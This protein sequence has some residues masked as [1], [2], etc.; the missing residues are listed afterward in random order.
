MKRNII[1]L[2]A[3]VFLVECSLYGTNNQETKN[4]RDTNVFVELDDSIGT[5][6]ESR[7]VVE[8][9][10][11]NNL[12]N[13]IG[14]NYRINDNYKSVANILNL[15]VNSDDIDS[16]KNIKGVK[17]V[18]KV[19]TFSCTNET[20]DYSYDPFE[21]SDKPDQNYS[22]LD[23]NIPNGL[24][25]GS[26]TMIAVLDDSFNINHEMFK[27]LTADFKYSKDDVDAIKNTDG[28][29]AKDAGYKNNKIPFYYSYSTKDNN[30]T[31][32]SNKTFHGGHVSGIAAANNT[33]EGIS[34]NSQLALMR[35]T[36]ARGS[37]DENAIIAALDDC[38]KLNVDVI[39]MSFGNSFLDYTLNETINSCF[40]NL[41]SLGIQV[42]VATGNDGRTKYDN[43][44][45]EYTSTNNVE[46]GEVG[47]FSGNKNVT[48]VGALNIKEDVTIKTS[49]SSYSG[50]SF[51]ARDQVT[52]HGVN[53]DGTSV[54]EKYEDIKPFYEFIEDG[55]DFAVLDYVVVP[56]LG[57]D[58]D[59]NDID[60]NGKIALISRGTITFV[61][62][63]RNAVKHG[64]KGVII[65][66]N[67]DNENSLDSTYIDF[68]GN[69]D[70]LEDEYY[71]PIA[72]TNSWAGELLLNQD[73]KKIIVGKDMSGDYSSEGALS[74]LSLK[75]DISAPGTNIYSGTSTDTDGVNSYAYYDGTSMA[76]PNFSGAY[77]NILSNYSGDDVVAYKKSLVARM[78]STA[79]PLKD[80]NGS[81]YSPR[82]LGAGSVDANGALLSEVYLVGNS[83]NKAKIELKNNN[84]VKNGRIKFS[85]E[86]HNESTESKKYKATLFVQAPELASV[87]NTLTGIANYKVRTDKDVL[88][89][90]STNDVVIATGT[91]SLD[92]N[93][94]ITEQNKEYL[95]NFDNGTYLEGYVIFESLDGGEDLSIPYLGF[96]GDYSKEEAVEPFTFEKS[97]DKLYGSDIINKM[98]DTYPAKN[99]IYKNADFNSIFATGSKAL[100]ESEISKITYNSANLLDYMSSVKYNDKKDSIVVGIEGLSTHIVIQQFVNRMIVDN[101]VSLIE[102]K[103]GDLVYQKYMY[104]LIKG[105][106]ESKTHPLTKSMTTSD[107]YSAGLVANRGFMT[108]DLVNES[109]DLIFKEGEYSLVFNYS[110]ASGGTYKKSYNITISSTIG[111]IKLS[112]EKKEVLYIDDKKYLRIYLN[113]DGIKEIKI[114]D[115]V[116]EYTTTDDGFYVDIDVSKFANQ[117]TIYLT[118]KDIY[119][120]NLNGLLMLS[121]IDD[122]VYSIFQSNI[123]EGSRMSA[124][125]SNPVDE[126]SNRTYFYNYVMVS[127]GN[128][129]ISF[130]DST[131]FS[132]AVPS[133]VIVSSDAIKVYEVDESGIEKEISFSLYQKNIVVE[134][135]TGKIKVVYQTVQE[136]VKPTDKSGVIIGICIGV[137]AIIIGAVVAVIVVKKLKKKETK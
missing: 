85:V 73:T 6:I 84:D 127:S 57:N 90:S 60:V 112:F 98:C 78:Q 95:K 20:E 25:S 2:I 9:N 17:S 62:K 130:D 96:Y 33:F 56:N 121:S 63:I 15:S 75:P 7:N 5:D 104:S 46:G 131:K 1:L 99:P 110:L 54:V 119:D 53:K 94:S 71:V 91:D 68:T 51:Y 38:A 77:A 120:K 36:N 107:M 111:T 49:F 133:D 47:S 66:N 74:D 59:Y 137:T 118:V 108:L 39:N 129:S 58:E 117:N 101:S 69:N 115:D 76:A 40:E 11:L 26:G 27:D 134:S 135:K 89:T 50:T 24:N 132:F 100:T 72:L 37:F 61:V 45:G 28:F 88:L 83:N 87:D 23:M 41:N 48:A 126:G 65:Y 114:G 136:E 4:I 123:P 10:F 35:V 42:S 81:Y 8:K 12:Q 103:T 14:L 18:S 55:K 113:G 3:S 124:S 93:V 70:P 44:I 122:G 97:N 16:I 13:N 106:S 21:G 102:S 22:R 80:A 86:T 43:G 19:R 34:P 116:L 30:L 109:G 32:T 125:I 29:N 31:Y 64:A 52:N 92:F 105:D 79:N 67:K 82:K 128:V